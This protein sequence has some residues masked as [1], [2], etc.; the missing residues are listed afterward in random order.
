MDILKR[1]DDLRKERG[2]SMYRLADEA[3]ITQSTIANMFSRKTLPS[4][5]TLQEICQAF[6]IS[7]SEFFGDSNNELNNNEFLLLANYRKLSTKNKG[8]VNT[9]INMLNAV[10][11]LEKS[12]EPSQYKTLYHKGLVDYKKEDESI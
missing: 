6:N 11:V 9:L 4:I 3:G 1:I 10:S 5:S 12:I 7:L 8:I 2:W